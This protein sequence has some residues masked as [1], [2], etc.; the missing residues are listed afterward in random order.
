MA[1]ALAR[2]DGVEGLNDVVLDQVVVR[3]ED[4]DEVTAEVI[5]RVQR[6]GTCWCGGS[7]FRG[8]D[9]MRISVVSWQT[10][11]ADIDISAR[12]ILACFESARHRVGSAASGAA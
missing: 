6:D 2:H 9:V 3:F 5:D 11:S 7:T 8:Q 10:T 12:A 4:S 1:S